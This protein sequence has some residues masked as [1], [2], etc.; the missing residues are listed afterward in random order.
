MKYVDDIE[1][2]FCELN[3]ILH[4]NLQFLDSVCDSSS[5]LYK[6]ISDNLDLYI[7][8][9]RSFLFA[10]NIGLDRVPDDI[11]DL[12]TPLKKKRK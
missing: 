4:N 9:Y 1:N 6:Y 10:N 12:I 5:E 8:K 3:L 7:N 11:R 2:T